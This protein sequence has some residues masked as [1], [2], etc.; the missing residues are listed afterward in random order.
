VHLDGEAVF[1]VV[2]DQR[3]PFYVLAAN[4]VTEDLGTRFGVRAYPGDPGVQVVVAEGKVALR[5][6][7]QAEGA[8]ADSG[9]TLGPNDLGRLDPRG[10]A[11]VVRGVNP[12]RYLAWTAGR[13]V[14]RQATLAEVA[15]QLERWYGVR[16][17]IGSPA[18]AGR[19]VTLDMPVQAMASVLNAITVALNVRYKATASG[20]VI[21]P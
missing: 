1:E 21:Y 17:E 12:E 9:A 5:A 4:A 14:F 7:E 13:L 6:R 19:R 3:R 11:T 2:H 10:R 16:I 20:V 15:V 8:A 18:L